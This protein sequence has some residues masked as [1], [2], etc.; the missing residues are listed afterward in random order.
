MLRLLLPAL[1]FCL[2]S[3]AAPDSGRFE[4]VWKAELHGRAYAVVTL[5][6]DHPPRGTIARGT[7]NTNSDGQVTEVTSD[8]A[9]N[10]FI[11]KPRII[12]GV[13][14]FKTIDPNDGEVDYEM[15]I[16]SPSQAMLSIAGAPA[17]PLKRD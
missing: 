8:A 12:K 3:S 13:L 2:S 15:K 17:F 9:M 11:Q 1:L 7:V 5:L 14:H 6:S 10:L 4:G 16:T